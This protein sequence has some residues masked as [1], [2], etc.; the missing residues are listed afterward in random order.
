MTDRPHSVIAWNGKE[1]VVRLTAKRVDSDE[2]VTVEMTLD[3]FA[4]LTAVQL[5]VETAPD[6]DLFSSPGV[7]YF[8]PDPETG[9]PIPRRMP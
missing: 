9:E 1:N 2:R 7:D 4:R 3:D 6:E 5:L 8:T